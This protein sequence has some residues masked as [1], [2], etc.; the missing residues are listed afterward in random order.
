MKTILLSCV[1]TLLA[2]VLFA[3]HS[4]EK[5]WETDSVT[6]KSPESVLYDSKSNSLYVSSMAA[7]TVVRFDLD[8]KLIQN[9]C[10]TGL[11]S[12]KGSAFFKGLFYTAEQTGIA[13]IDL[14]KGSVIKHI[15]V[16]GAIML[17]DVAI[18]PEGVVYV[19]DTRAGKV[20]RI[21]NDKP[22]LFLENR[23]GANGLLFVGSDL[24]VLTSTAIEKVSADKKVTKVADDFESGLDAIV[25][26]G[27]NEFIISNYKGMLYYLNADG[28]KQVLLD[29]RASH[30]GANDIG[31]NDKSKT[32]YVPSFGTNRIIAYKVK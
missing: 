22:V 14:T 27:K 18:D 3:Q 23:P 30:I 6:L 15:P 7:G 13:V 10:V 21:E 25:A 9:N 20:Y 2:S 32:L 24:Y 12:N 17:N 5:L 1:L 16:K 4:L 29:T 31:Y 26:V 28:T 19:T 8:G 11:N